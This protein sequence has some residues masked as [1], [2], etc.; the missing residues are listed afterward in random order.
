MEFVFGLVMGAALTI[1]TV[2]AFR[3]PKVNSASGMRH[4]MRSNSGFSEK[5]KPAS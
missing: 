5:S 1:L 3:D 4:V 2:S